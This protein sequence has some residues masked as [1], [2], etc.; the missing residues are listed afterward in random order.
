MDGHAREEITGMS[1]EPAPG[2]MW[3]GAGAVRRPETQPRSMDA[4]QADPADIIK[5][6][7]TLGHALVAIL[8][9]GRDIAHE[10]GSI[11]HKVADL[12][13]E[14][15]AALLAIGPALDMR[16]RPAPD[17]DL[18]RHSQRQASRAA[19]TERLLENHP[20]AQALLLLLDERPEGWSG[21]T[22]ALL[23]NLNELVDDAVR[24]SPRWPQTPQG[25]RTAL[26]RLAPGMAAVGIQITRWRQGHGGTRMLAIRRESQ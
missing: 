15:E 25:L 14:L 18:Y 5:S 11:A 13:R 20:V 21:S 7:S 23:H 22:Q 2:N 19:A 3:H 24:R 12:S 6:V 1:G 17:R 4:G 26:Q 10:L 8:D 16:P 9:A